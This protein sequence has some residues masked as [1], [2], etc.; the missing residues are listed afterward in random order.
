[1]LQKDPM[2]KIFLYLLTTFGGYLIISTVVELLFNDFAFSSKIGINILK[3]AV[4]LIII[5][6]VLSVLFYYVDL[7]IAKIRKKPGKPVQ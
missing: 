5:A 6:I 3:K 7:L 1:M 4:I 2:K